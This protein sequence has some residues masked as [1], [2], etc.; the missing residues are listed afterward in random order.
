MLTV[1]LRA[2][3][4]FNC[5]QICLNNSRN[6]SLIMSFTTVHWL[7]I[8]QQADWVSFASLLTHILFRSEKKQY[9]L[10][11]LDTWHG[12][13]YLPYKPRYQQH[14]DCNPTPPPVTSHCV[15]HNFVILY[16]TN[17]RCR[18]NS[19]GLCYNS[20]VFLSLQW[21]SSSQLCF[22]KLVWAPCFP[23]AFDVLHPVEVLGLG[24]LHEFYNSFCV[25]YNCYQL[26]NPSP[27][28]GHYFLPSYNNWVWKFKWVLL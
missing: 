8:V 16:F 27:I 17:L 3:S 15:V 20:S 13:A 5:L 9:E 18:G 25:D 10:E 21:S 6:S 19:R 14:F 2:L 11:K 26:L 22:W 4:L 24:K 12:L 28:N 1:G 23:C 7:H